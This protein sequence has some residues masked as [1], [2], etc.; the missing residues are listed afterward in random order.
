MLTLVNEA[1][2]LYLCSMKQLTFYKYQGTGNDFVMVDN[3]SDFFPKDNVQLIA[4]LCDRRFGIGAD[5]LILLE[6][7]LS[8]DFKMVYYNADGNQSTMCGNGGRCIV[9]FAHDLGVIQNQTVF[10]AVDGLHHAT[11]NND[12]IVALQMIDV[13]KNTIESNTN[14]TFL[15]TGSPHHVQ[16]VQ[17]LNT[18]NVFENGKTIRYSEKYKP[19]GT[20]VNFVE[21]LNENSL[22]IRTYERGVENETLACGT[23]AT[24]VAIAT[25]FLGKT[26]VN[27]I[28]IKVQGGNVTVTF[29]HD[30]EKYFNVHLTGPALQVFKGEIKI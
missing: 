16:F 4:H 28:A 15:F 21:Q 18:F 10:N 3:R 17:N 11:I 13:L 19:G 29:E 2:I 6:N 9:A 14:D 25:H 26:S 8:A 12:K 20:N 24:A 1:L 7:D 5:G 23:G 30:L 22:E 27:E